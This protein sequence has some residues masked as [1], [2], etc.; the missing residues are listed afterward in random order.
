M[1]HSPLFLSQSFP[2]PDS[3]NQYS[4]ATAALADD[5]SMLTLIQKYRNILTYTVKSKYL[6]IVMLLI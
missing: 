1:C 5:T 2:F 6:Y 4:A 3:S